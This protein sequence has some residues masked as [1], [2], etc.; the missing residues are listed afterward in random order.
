[1]KNKKAFIVSILLL[2]LLL[3]TSCQMPVA[4]SSEKEHTHD[5]GDWEVTKVA[6]A[7]KE[8]RE[9]RSCEC[10][11]TEERK[12]PKRTDLD[13]IYEEATELIDKEKYEDAYLLLQSLGDY[14]DA[15]ELVKKFR[16]VLISADTGED[17]S[18]ELTLTDNNLPR[19]FT[20]KTAYSE[21]TITCYYD[22]NGR[23]IKEVVGELG[24]QNVIE[25]T[26]DENGNLIKEEFKTNG[27]MGTAS[28][29]E[30][31]YDE[32]GNLIKKEY[33]HSDRNGETTEIHE[34]TYDKNGNLIKEEYESISSGEED[35][36]TL[37]SDF[38]YDK[39]GN[40][41]KKISVNSEDDETVY[42]CTYDKSGNLVKECTQYS[43]GMDSTFEYT[44]DKNGNLIKVVSDYYNR[45]S[46]HEYSYDKNG[47]MIEEVTT[48]YDEN[49]EIRKHT[50]DK[51]GNLIK[52]VVSDLEGETI[53]TYK[54]EW[55]LV[56]IVFDLSGEYLDE[57]FAKGG[58]RYK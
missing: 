9:E 58:I 31:T 4:G 32:N 11:E 5:F 38:T 17:N 13:N 49:G 43:N 30:Y 8:G 53:L 18:Y 1:M 54:Y 22:Q 20:T 55:E 56:Y 10:G 19:R 47:N 2:T 44:Y 52:T 21:D 42:E 45:E 25:Y 39:N 24:Y 35:K 57:L 34:Y 46:V 41:T 50:Y 36:Y 28:V 3:F 40:L 16:Y 7:S 12:I 29:T 26:Y 37:V 15:E 14:K 6:T 33:A 27:F 48:T 23:L 51:N